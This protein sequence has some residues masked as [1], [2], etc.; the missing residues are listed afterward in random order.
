MVFFKTN[1]VLTQVPTA[2]A[3]RIAQLLHKPTND[4]LFFPPERFLPPLTCQ[5]ELSSRAAQKS[6]LVN[7]DVGEVGGLEELTVI[8]THSSPPALRTHPALLS[9]LQLP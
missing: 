2:K 5:L 7:A 1:S 6:A 3:C 4:S 8:E 9:G